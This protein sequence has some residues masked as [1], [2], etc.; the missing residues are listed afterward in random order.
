[1]SSTV[2]RKICF[3]VPKAIL[4]F[5]PTL[6][7]P[8]GGAERQAYYLG[9]GLAKQEGWD[10]H[11]CTAKYG[12]V[13]KF[14]QN[15]CTLWPTFRFEDGT[16]SSF[17]E[18]CRTLKKIDAD[19]YVFR[20]ANMAIA[21]VVIYLKSLLKKRCVYM[22]AHDEEGS[23]RGLAKMTNWPTAAL[24][25]L[26]HRMANLVTVQTHLQLR[27]FAEQGVKNTHL[28]RNCFRFKEGERNSIEPLELD[29]F[30][31][32][33]GRC[34]PWK[35]PEIFIELARNH[36]EEQFIMIC[37]RGRDLPYFEKLRAAASEIRNLE[38]IDG[39]DPTLVMNYFARAKM[40]VLTS[41]SEGFANTM[42]EAM[43]QACPLL[44]L[45]ID[46]DGIISEH[47]LGRVALSNEELSQQFVSLAGNA[48]LRKKLGENGRDY[49]LRYHSEEEV[50]TA[51]SGMLSSLFTR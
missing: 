31:L 26:T 45:D 24:M 25:W 44:T 40:Y 2:L 14:Q 47:T 20:A 39:V 4:F 48:E 38:F 15:N 32:W 3:V 8:R 19:V 34:D 5:D 28:L 22:V 41:V 37:P 27:C 21:P 18:L 35:Q 49:L 36:S 11:Y 16:F 7:T 50:V 29:G 33:V 6:G 12:D 13:G 1:M 46:P 42:M 51:F 23:F 10:V 17:V 43:S 9:T 30:S